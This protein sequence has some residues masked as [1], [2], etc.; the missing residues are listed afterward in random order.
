VKVAKAERERLFAMFG[1]RCA[2][3][4]CELQKGWHADHVDPVLRGVGKAVHGNPAHH[5][6]RHRTDNLFPS[7]PPCNLDKGQQSIESY[8]EWIKTHLGSLHRK[9][10]YK[11]VLRHGLIVETDAPVVFHFER[12]TA[13]K[14]TP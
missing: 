6:D 9:S 5:M 13:T 3:C 2:Y 11:S 1:G 8:R 14:D 10:I 12:V 7:C 4:G